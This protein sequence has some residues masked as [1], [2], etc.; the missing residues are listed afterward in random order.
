MSR[1]APCCFLVLLLASPARAAGPYDDLLKYAPASAN[2]LLLVDV[3]GA[4]ASPLAKREK[5]GAATDPDARGGLGFA[6]AD[7]EAVAVAADVN[8]STMARA[9]QVGLVKVPNLPNLRDLAARE[10]GTNDEI[11]GQVAALSPR[12]V[13]FTALPAN[14]LVAVHPADRQYTARYLKAAG[15]GA[16]GLS[17]YLKKAAA[18]A[19]ANAVTIAVDLED[20][21]DRTLLKLSLPASPVASKKGVDIGLLATF[22]SQAKGLTFA[23]K[24]G[25]SITAGVTVEFPIEPI[26]FRHTLPDLIRELLEDQG[27][28]I[29][30]F[31][32]W[33]AEYTDTTITLSGPMSATDLRR[34]VSLFA[35]PNPAAAADPDAKGDAPTAGATRRYLRAVEAI[36]ADVSRTR[37]TASY[38][39]TATWHEKAA[40]GIAR[41]SRRHVDPL[42]A[43]A[44]AG[45]EARLRAIGHSLRGVPI[46][47]KALEAK[48][49]AWASG[50]TGFGIVPTWWGL[51]PRAFESPTFVDTNIPQIRSQI[52]KATAEDKER[53]AET[54]GAIDKLM[55]DA[56]QALTKK[57]N[58]PF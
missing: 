49:Y 2:A 52:A 16:G 12:D 55:I 31:E 50:G 9:F 37:G 22:L 5:W 33:K 38:E 45:A 17:P 51:R 34:V 32:N 58:T 35:F 10:G 57:Y 24:I 6:P 21:L 47:T 13:Y 14:T 11:A 8:L 18:G 4:Y 30:G 39:K 36:L 15:K 48:Q 44:A 3:K 42:A 28:A 29:D 1:A 40:D 20:A 56:K 54:W 19:G 27:I 25:D 26:R 46:D 41:L 53:R 23:A 43:D 7:A